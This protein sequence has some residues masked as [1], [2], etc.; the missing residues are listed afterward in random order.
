MWLG[1]AIMAFVTAQRLAEIVRER[2]NPPSRAS[3]EFGRSA[4]ELTWGEESK[5]LWEEIYPDLSEGEEG[6][7][8]GILGRAETHVL[9]LA[10]LYA[11]TDVGTWKLLRR[12]LGHSRA[13]TTAVLQSLIRAALATAPTP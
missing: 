2:S 6:L 5:H 13:E 3:V 12:D 1:V 10:A 7:V 4:G 11:V 9:R 8:G